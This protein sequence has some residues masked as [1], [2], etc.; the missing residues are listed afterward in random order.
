MSFLGKGRKSDLIELGTELGVTIPPEAV[1]VNIKRLI[2]SSE[3][4]DEEF[5]KQVFERIKERIKREENERLK[6]E[7]EKLEKE[8]KRQRQMKLKR[9]RKSKELL[10]WK[11]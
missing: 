4:Y 6:K 1:I 8:K 7:N 2:T 10:N 3:N 11:N 9:K 5:V